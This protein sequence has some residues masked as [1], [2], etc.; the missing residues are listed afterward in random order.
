MRRMHIPDVENALPPGTP[1]GIANLL[2]YKPEVAKHLT[3]LAQVVMRGESP[4]SPG[5]RELI[6]A[7]VSDENECHF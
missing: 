1:S 4:L 6:A 7:V 2:A 5:Q 3:A